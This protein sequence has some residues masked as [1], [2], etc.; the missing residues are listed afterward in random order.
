MTKLGAVVLAAA[1][2]LGCNSNSTG[3]QQGVSSSCT[4]TL[5]GAVSGTYDCRP[6][7]TSYGGATDNTGFTFGVRASGSQPAIGLT[8]VWIG[9]PTDSIYRNMDGTYSYKYTDIGAQGDISVTTS[10]GQTWLATIGEGPPAAGTYI[11]TFTSVTAN[12]FTSSGGLYDG[13]GTVTAT[14]PAVASSGATGTIIL[15]ATF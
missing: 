4:V 7:T 15:S 3:P 11:L 12:S 10:N 9:I 6:A 5:S 1:G 14:L 8:V 13:E 2:I